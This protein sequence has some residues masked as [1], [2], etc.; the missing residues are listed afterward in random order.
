T[1]KYDRVRFEEAKLGLDAEQEITRRTAFVSILGRLTSEEMLDEITRLGPQSQLA[2]RIEKTYWR[3]F[4]FPSMAFVLG[5]VASAI[6]LSGRARSRA[7][8]GVLGMLAV[9]GY[10][11]LTRI[12]DFF[13]VQYEGTPF[14]MAWGPN[15]LVLILAIFALARAGR[16]A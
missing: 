15:A 5:L 12:A 3:R 8:S 16:P 11:V 1:E 2:R 4:A 7:R 10:Y 14:W 13:V 6:A 9:I